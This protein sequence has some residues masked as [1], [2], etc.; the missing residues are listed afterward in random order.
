MGLIL[1]A[2]FVGIPL[3]EIMLFIKIG[4]AI[5]MGAT[6]LTVV[7]T[8]FAGSFL[9]RWQGL[10][11]LS[12]AQ[13]ALDRAELPVDSVIHGIFLVVAG[14][15]LL[16]PGFLTDGIGFALFV[17]PLRLAAGR[18]IWKYI[19]ARATVVTMSTHRETYQTSDVIDGEA[20]EIDE[21][22]PR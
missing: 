6:V 5:G 2:L 15:F 4:G 21:D 18:A 8:A 1:F 22:E 11:V 7:L 10:Q 3:I 17:P 20:E 14:A 16:T 19:S 13:G 12:E 9:L